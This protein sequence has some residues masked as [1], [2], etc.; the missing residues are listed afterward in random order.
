MTLLAKPEDYPNGP[1]PRSTQCEAPPGVVTGRPGPIE[2][3]VEAQEVS[4]SDTTI[5]TARRNLTF[6][7]Y[8]GDM[9]R[10]V[11]RTKDIDDDSNSTSISSR[12]ICVNSG[13]TLVATVWGWDDYRTTIT[14]PLPSYPEVLDRHDRILRGVTKVLSGPGFEP[15]EHVLDSEDMSVRFTVDTEQ[16]DLEGDGL[17]SCGEI[18]YGTDP[19]DADTDDDGLTD[20]AEVNTYGTDPLDADT[21]DDGLTDSA[22]VSTHSTD[23]NDADTDHDGLT[24]GAEVNTY[25]TIPLD[26]DTDDDGLTDGAEVN[27]HGTD[28]LNADTDDD[29][30]SDSQELQVGTNPLNPDTDGDGLPDGQDVDWIEEAIL[31][32]PEDAING[33]GKKG[34]RNA[35]LNLL[36]DA[37]AHLLRGKTKPAMDK[38]TTLRSRIDGCGSSPDS[39]DWVTD[40]AEQVRIRQLLDILIANV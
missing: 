39:N 34:N 29:G 14:Q 24:D 26:A 8:T 19:N 32:I 16:S 37:E 12:R 13:D 9:R 31:A 6:A 3:I 11:Y 2:V 23:P 30:L 22:E 15:G 10:S 5:P 35:M 1:H 17:S 18:F 4:L 38:L 21:D 20:G 7:L 33:S 27:T 28:P 36:A 25:S 40:C